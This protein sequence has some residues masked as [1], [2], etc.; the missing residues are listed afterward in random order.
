MLDLIV[1]NKIAVGGLAIVIAIIAW[2]V[3]RDAGGV[4]ENLLL[5]ENIAAGSEADRDLVATLLQLRTVSLSGTIFSDPIFQTL[6]D[7]GSQI[8]PEPVGRPNPFAPLTG[9]PGPA[10]VTGTSTAT[11]SAQQSSGPPP[12]Q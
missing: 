11:S 8:I 12:R 9:G 3:L 10:P 4:Q 1:R 5:T 7:F 2:Y 6:Q